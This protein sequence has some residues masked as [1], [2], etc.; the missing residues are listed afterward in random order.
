MGS[1]KYLKEQMLDG[2]LKKEQNDMKQQIE[3]L[4]NLLCLTK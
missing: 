1:L 2:K 3:G 4:R